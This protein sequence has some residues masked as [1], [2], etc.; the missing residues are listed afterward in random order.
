MNLPFVTSAK[1]VM[2]SPGFVCGFV[3]LFVS[4]CIC[5]EDNSKTYVR[6]LM[7]ISGYV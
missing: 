7:K 6:I 4:L 3:S 1:D 2:F 5:E